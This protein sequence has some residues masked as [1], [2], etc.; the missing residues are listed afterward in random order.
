MGFATK[1]HFY[2]IMQLDDTRTDLMQMV[3]SFADAELKPIADEMDRTMK[4]PH[5]LWKLMGDQGLLG[6]TAAE[7]YGGLGLGYYEHC[8]VVEQIS[9]ANAAVGLSYLAHSNLCINQF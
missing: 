9:K 7:E 6:I 2:K 5:H 1:D 4:F 8:L 3:E